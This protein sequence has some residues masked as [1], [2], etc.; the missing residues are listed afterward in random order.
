M[1]RNPLEMKRPNPD[2]L[3]SGAIS[4]RDRSWWQE[5]TPDEKRPSNEKNPFLMKRESSWW[6]ETPPNEKRIL[7]MK[8]DPS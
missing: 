3:S 6:K 8:R 1:E 2:I 7:Q 4:K 5:T